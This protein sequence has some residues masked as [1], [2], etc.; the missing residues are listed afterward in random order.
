MKVLQVV[1]R[2]Q[3]GG[4]G[5]HHGQLRRIEGGDD[6]DEDPPRT[7]QYP[8]KLQLQTDYTDISDRLSRK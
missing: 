4:G 6:R 1:N 2:Q 3:P 7:K 5:Q 8:D